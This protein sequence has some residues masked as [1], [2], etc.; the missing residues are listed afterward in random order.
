MGH[1][2]QV[3]PIY[4]T[5]RPIY[6][7]T[8]DV[9]VGGLGYSLRD[10]TYTINAIDFGFSPFL[11]N[12]APVAPIDF[13]WGGRVLTHG[14]PDRELDKL[15][16]ACGGGAPVR[17]V[18]THDDGWER[19]VRAR[20]ESIDWPRDANDTI[21]VDAKVTWKINEWWTE[22]GYA[23]QTVAGLGT[24]IV[25]AVAGGSTPLVCGTN[26]LP[27]LGGGGTS[28]Y[29]FPTTGTTLA[30]AS[31]AGVGGI[32]NQ[33]DTAV[34]IDVVGPMGGDDGFQIYIFATV[35]KDKNGQDFNPNI[36]THLFVPPG[37]TCVIDSGA[38][39]IAQDGLGD[40]TGSKRKPDEQPYWAIVK[41]L[42]NNGIGISSVGSNGINYYQPVTFVPNGSGQFPSTGTY[43]LQVVPP[44]FGTQTTGFLHFNDPPATVQA[45]LQLMGGLGVGQ[46]RVTA[47]LWQGIY[48]N[49]KGLPGYN[50]MFIGTQAGVT[51][52]TMTSV[53]TFDR[54]TISIA[55]V[56]GSLS[57]KWKRKYRSA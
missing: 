56:Y 5:S 33:D 2:K 8:D 37:S 36:G 50:V 13:V 6:V 35:L 41:S 43:Q 51:I 47:G 30:D 54:G 25:A 32:P 12:G 55:T 4:D 39:S 27:I 53:N 3:E 21:Y 34:V 18:W 57:F 19:V 20:L 24:P 10:A 42:V 1:L 46:V 45:A 16:T 23:N 7:F 26:A 31:V 44:G 9:P 15:T 17:L 11:D 22:R 28:L 14:H 49:A 29:V 38:Q 52:P 48:Y 40:I